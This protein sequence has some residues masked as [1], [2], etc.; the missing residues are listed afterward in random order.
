MTVIK[1]RKWL[2]NERITIISSRI[3]GDAVGE[4]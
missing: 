1:D 4:V 2:F 3:S